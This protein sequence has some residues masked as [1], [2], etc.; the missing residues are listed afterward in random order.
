MEILYLTCTLKSF[1]RSLHYISIWVASD[2]FSILPV[3]CTRT[4]QSGMELHRLP[5]MFKNILLSVVLDFQIWK[6]IGPRFFYAQSN[7]DKSFWDFNICFWMV[8]QQ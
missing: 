4:E 3:T 7:Y 6:D 8:K 2:P 1:Y 5:G